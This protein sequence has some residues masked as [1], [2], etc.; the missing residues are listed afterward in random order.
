MKHEERDGATSAFAF[1]SIKEINKLKK[2]YSIQDALKKDKLYCIAI[3]ILKFR[4]ENV[5]TVSKL[6]NKLEI[7]EESAIGLIEQLLEQDYIVIHT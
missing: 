5:L 6:C 2:K 7:T 4:Y 3:L 1:P